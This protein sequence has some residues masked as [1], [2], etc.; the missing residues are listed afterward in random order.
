MKQLLLALVALT[1]TC[2]FYPKTVTVK[3]DIPNGV[4]NIEMYKDNL[5]NSIALKMGYGEYE[6]PGDLETYLNAGKIGE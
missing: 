2:D 6:Y 3:V 1:V 4:K 5:C